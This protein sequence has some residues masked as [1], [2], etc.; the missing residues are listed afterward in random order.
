MKPSTIITAAALLCCLPAAAQQQS[1]T[2]NTRDIYIRDP[3]ILPVEKTRTYYMYSS[4]SMKNEAGHDVGGVKVYKSKDLK[5]WTGPVQ[6]CQLPETNWSAGA[7]WAPEVH[8][9]KGKYWLFATINS[10]IEWKK[11]VSGWPAY[12]WRGTQI[13]KADSPEGPFLPISRHQQTPLDQM[14]LDGTLWVENEQPYMIYCHEWVQTA[15]GTVNALPL[16]SDLSHATGSPQMLF[17][18]SAATWSTGNNL[19][20]GHPRAY[21]TDGVFLYRTKTGRLLMIWS[22]YC[23]GQYATGIAE[24]VTGTVAGP[25]R[26]QPQTLFRQDGGHA[27]IFRTFDGQLALVLH[28]PNSGGRERAHI[29]KLEDTGNSLRLGE[30]MK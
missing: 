3:F 12:T 25:W 10:D 2:M 11:P 7:I 14:A 20:T 24:S 30:E 28:Q 27:M 22:S 19:G 1:Q 29:Y 8:R 15:D 26:Q 17:A 4:Q 13:F 16:S 23:D 9:Y 5:T 18:G 21:I 6:V